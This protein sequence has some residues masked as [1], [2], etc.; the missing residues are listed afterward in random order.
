MFQ[1]LKVD[2]VYYKTNTDFEMEFNLCGCCRMRLLTDKSPDRKTALHS[3]ARAVS[4]SRIIIVTGS[5]FGEE[6]I[7]KLVSGAIGFPLEKI[8]K[9]KYN[10]SGDDELE[11]LK[12]ATPLVTQDGY[13]GGCIVESGPQTMILISENKTIRK[14]IM[15]TLIHPYVEELCATELK[16][17]AAAVSE[18]SNVSLVTDTPEESN[19]ENACET[20]EIEDEILIGTEE[21]D[22]KPYGDTVEDSGLIFDAKP[23]CNEV[24]LENA[25]SDDEL[26]VEVT[27]QID[28]ESLLINDEYDEEIDTEK[29]AAETDAIV[30]SGMIFETDEEIEIK[31]VEDEVEDDIIAD[32]EPED[33]FSNNRMT[34]DNAQDDLLMEDDDYFAEPPRRFS[35]SLNLTIMIVAI[36]M[37]VLLAVLCY[38]IFYI[39]AKD[40]VS[41]SEY[42]KETFNI[43]FGKV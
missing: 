12:G 42:I 6:G 29:E 8:E 2:I 25:I 3:L 34:P 27:D 13:F 40:G 35:P 14:S 9:G 23:D 39:P 26:I 19:N 20:E 31:P 28:G 30:S 38:C 36:L 15:Q 21:T 16:E 22:A 4:R 43:L 41:A 32:T 33:I 11:I 5:L 1:N 24:L 17:K 7:I 37:L 10:I 18:N